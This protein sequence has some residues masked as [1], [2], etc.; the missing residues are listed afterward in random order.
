MIC[1]MTGLGTAHQP[2][3]CVCVC[4]CVW[5]MTSQALKRTPRSHFRC[6]NRRLSSAPYLPS[7]RTLKFESGS[8]MYWSDGNYRNLGAKTAK[9]TLNRR[10]GWG[11]R[12]REWGLRSSGLALRKLVSGYLSLPV[13]CSNPIH[14]SP[15]RSIRFCRYSTK[16]PNATENVDDLLEKISKN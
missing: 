7:R 4:V 14:I 2:S 1:R 13:P 12:S 6:S 15:S 16:H 5:H 9:T 8:S 10:G 3:L 11:L